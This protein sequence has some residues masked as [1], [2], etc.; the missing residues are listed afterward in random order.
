LYAGA[1]VLI[2]LAGNLAGGG[3]FFGLGAIGFALHLAWQVRS[4]D[5]E[6]PE[7]CLRLFR[8]NR[9]A[10]LILFAGIV[11]D[12]LVGSPGAFFSYAR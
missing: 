11:L 2:S 8:S 10:G 4:L 12:G 3:I 1:V 6:H 5:I 9:E 7:H